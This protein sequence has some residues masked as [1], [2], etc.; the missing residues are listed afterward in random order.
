M[1]PFIQFSILKVDRTYFFP[2]SQLHAYHFLIYTTHI[3]IDSVQTHKIALNA[4]VYAFVNKFG[5]TLNATEKRRNKNKGKWVNGTIQIETNSLRS[6][7]FF[8]NVTRSSY[9]ASYGKAST[10]ESNGYILNG[11]FD[12]IFPS[13][14][15]TVQSSEYGDAFTWAIFMNK[16]HRMPNR[17]VC[18]FTDEQS[19]YLE[20]ETTYEKEYE[21][22]R[23]STHYFEIWI[24]K[25]C[26]G[27]ISSLS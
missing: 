2:T 18:A 23:N 5:I 25:M 7:F 27:S 26:C 19:T 14:A 17:Y 13:S 15:G 8:K 3:Q 24:A 10:L 9:V 6:I 12:F 11:I 20:W 22:Q 1:N 16:C 4:L 21:I